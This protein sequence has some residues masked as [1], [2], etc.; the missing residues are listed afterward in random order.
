MPTR[1]GYRQG[2]W[3][4]ARFEEYLTELQEHQ[5]LVP[6]PLIRPWKDEEINQIVEALCLALD[7]S[8]FIGT[9]IGNFRGSNQSK[10]NRAA[11]H[12]VA[13]VPPHLPA[14]CKVQVA[15]GKGYPD[16]LCIL[17]DMGFALE[18]KATSNW[19]DGDSNRRV[20]TSS[21][22]KMLALIASGDLDNPPPHLICSVL[23]K[24]DGVV[25]GTRLD[26]LEPESEV[27]IRLEASTSQKL[28]AAGP[29]KYIILP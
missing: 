11:E 15:A 18:L 23:Y 26:F 1:V 13:T 19:Q 12:F 10:G 5:G 22:T 3:A 28:L 21:P 4:L 7:S 24:E 16:L 29:H 17:N 25:T 20:L 27:N 14:Y 6:K 2:S 9:L 8:R